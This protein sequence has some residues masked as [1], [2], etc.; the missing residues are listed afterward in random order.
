MGN[1][2]EKNNGKD[3]HPAMYKT[4]LILAMVSFTLGSLVNFYTLK[5]LKGK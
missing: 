3:V 4:F 2:N 5:R 1:N